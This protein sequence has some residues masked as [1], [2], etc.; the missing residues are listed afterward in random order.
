MDW[1]RET[2]NY[3]LWLCVPPIY[4]PYHFPNGQAL[5]PQRLSL[6]QLEN[7]SFQFYRL[8]SLFSSFIA[9]WT[10]NIGKQYDGRILS[11]KLQCKGTQGKLLNSCVHFK[12]SG[13]RKYRVSM[14]ESILKLTEKS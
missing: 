1:Q 4:P 12:K 9:Q 8:S 7:L 13:S 5:Q 10:T 2:S 3:T 11:L 6:T 14:L